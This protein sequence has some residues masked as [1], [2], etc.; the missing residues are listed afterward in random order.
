[1]STTKRTQLGSE[2]YKDWIALAA[3]YGIEQTTVK[4]N[5]TDRRDHED[6]AHALIDLLYKRGVSIVS[7]RTNLEKIN[8]NDL[9]AKLFTI[10]REDLADYQ[11][12]QVHSSS[13]V[14]GAPAL[15]SDSP[16]TRRFP[17]FLLCCCAHELSCVSSKSSGSLWV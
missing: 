10:E 16:R 8:R 15:A 6:C 13:T 5:A 1:V 17:R 7:L 12:Q 2:L 4:R 9:C 14:A 3:E 11:V